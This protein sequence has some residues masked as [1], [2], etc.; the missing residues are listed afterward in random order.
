MIKKLEINRFRC[1][2]K[3][4]VNNLAPITI[5]GGRNNAGKSA[6]LDSILLS[7]IVLAPVYFTILSSIRGENG[8]LVSPHQIWNPLFYRMGNSDSLSI[9]YKHDDG[10]TTLSLS[11]IY[12]E[13]RQAMQMPIEGMSRK[14]NNSEIKKNFMLAMAYNDFEQKISGKY[15][16][17]RN[18]AGNNFIDFQAAKEITYPIVSIESKLYYKYPAAMVQTPEWVSQIGLEPEKKTM[19]IE[20]LKSFDRDITDIVTVLENGET[21]VYVKFKSKEAI[22][23]TYMGDGINKAVSLLLCIINLPDGVLLI[24]EVEN[25]LYF[26]LYEEII[27]VMIDTAL[28]VNC[29]IIMTTHNKDLISATARIMEEKSKLDKISYIRM[30]LAR[31]RRQAFDFMGSDLISA[32]N[33]NTEMR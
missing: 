12:I 3:L 10:K 9:S 33:S 25:G 17:Q 24:D 8:R 23:L 27:P 1:F 20:A 4:V 15:S 26:G 11:K 18:A 22:P 13:Y 30:D 6:L 29:Q 31:G 19:L 32:I 14:Y 16:L 5:I 7:N 28:G 21:F 2:D